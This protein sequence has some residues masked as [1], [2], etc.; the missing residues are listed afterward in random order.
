MLWIGPSETDVDNAALGKRLWA[1]AYPLR[2]NS[3]ILES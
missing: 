1:A 3:E 2:V